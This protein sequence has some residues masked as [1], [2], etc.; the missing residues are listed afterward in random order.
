MT[1][2]E[3]VLTCLKKGFS[4]NGRASRSEFWFF[5][6]F[7]TMIYLMSILIEDAYPQWGAISFLI[8]SIVFAFPQ[9][10]V[11]IRRFHD[12][13]KSGWNVF[14]SLLIFWGGIFLISESLISQNSTNEGI[15]AFLAIELFNISFYQERHKRSQ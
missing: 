6:L 9:I 11:A 3:A 2:G 15:M 4:F 1:F 5:Q 12:V 8:I 7:I 13:N 10:A 14:W